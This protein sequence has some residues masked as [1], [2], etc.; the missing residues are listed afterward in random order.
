MTDILILDF[1]KREESEILLNSL[2]SYIKFPYRVIFLDNGSY[3]NY[4]FDFY[5]NGLIDILIKN[6]EGRGLGY[7]T[8]QLFAAAESE[9]CLYIQNDQYLWRDF[10]KEELGYLQSAI[11]QN[12]NDKKIKSIS[13]AGNI[14]GDGIYSERAHLIKSD[15][16]KSLEPLSI[17]G[18]GKYH[19]LPWREGQLQDTYKNNNYTHYIYQHPLFVDNGKCAI[20]ENPDGSLWKHEPDTKRL[21]LIRGPVKEKFIYPYF[22][23]TEWGKVLETQSWPD[24][25]IPS[26]EK[27]NS[28]IVDRWH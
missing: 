1:N 22:D 6:K 23:E 9:F 17:G 4:S 13:L 8:K 7:G 21:F 11:D 16:Y 3:I 2:K 26:K 24:G 10:T 12:L 28:F 14:C 20:R 27:E 19:N 18:A 15:F 25:Q 5:Q